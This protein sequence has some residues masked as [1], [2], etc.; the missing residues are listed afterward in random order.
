[1]IP[2]QTGNAPQVIPSRFA[3]RLARMQHN[4][5]LYVILRVIDRD[6]YNGCTLG[7]IY[8]DH[9]SERIKITMP[10]VGISHHQVLAMKAPDDG[11]DFVNPEFI[12]LNPLD[13]DPNQ[14][15]LYEF[16]PIRQ[17]Y[18]PGIDVAAMPDGSTVI[19]LDKKFC[20]E[21]DPKQ[22]FVIDYLPVANLL[23]PLGRY[24]RT[25]ILNT[26]R[27]R[28][29][30]YGMKL[31]VGTAQE[32]VGHSDYFQLLAAPGA[33]YVEPDIGTLSEFRIDG[34]SRYLSAEWSVN[35]HHLTKFYRPSTGDFV[36]RIMPLVESYNGRESSGAIRYVGFESEK[37]AQ[38]TDSKRRQS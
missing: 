5:E 27:G 14:N 28:A 7:A 25:L 2:F 36:F 18:G 22:D 10:D 11:R 19:W 13:L 20:E 24:E 31:K 17:A 21:Q 15:P 35:H 26:V 3:N 1:M 33:D 16:T 38:Y 29:A 32:N 8:G 6:N 4:G 34:N 30:Q 9:V 23:N 37:A 12:I